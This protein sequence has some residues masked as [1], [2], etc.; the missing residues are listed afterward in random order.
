MHKCFNIFIILFYMF[1]G[2]LCSSSGGQIVLVQHMV[3]GI[4]TLFRWLFGAQVNL[5]TEQTP[6][7]SDDTRYQM[8]Q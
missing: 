1:R 4:V 3:S 5:C 6:K 8:L 2:L 7:E